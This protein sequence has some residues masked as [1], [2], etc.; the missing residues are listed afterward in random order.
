M[1][2]VVLVL[3]VAHLKLEITLVVSRAEFDELQLGLEKGELLD[4][5]RIA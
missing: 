1:I 2:T 5:V 4:L 3:K